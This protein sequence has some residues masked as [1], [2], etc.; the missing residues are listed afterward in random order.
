MKQYRFIRNKDTSI[1]IARYGIKL[2]QAEKRLFRALIR[3]NYKAD[4]AESFT[5]KVQQAGNPH[6][7]KDATLNALAQDG[8]TKKQLGRVV[9]LAQACARYRNFIDL[10]K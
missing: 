3:N 5:A 7:V 9:E 1:E 2:H 8:L 10:S 4:F 6:K